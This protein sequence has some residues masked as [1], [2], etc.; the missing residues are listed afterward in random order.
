MSDRTADSAITR[1]WPAW[2]TALLLVAAALLL[3]APAF[4][5]DPAPG[6][7]PAPAA[8]GV[9]AA[10]DGGAPPEDGVPVP[11]VAAADSAA[12][13][14]RPAYPSNAQLITSKKVKLDKSDDNVVRTG[15]GERYAI[16]GLYPKG[17]VFPV[18][19]KSGDWYNVRLSESETGWIHSALCRE[20]DDLSDLEFKPN[21][22]LYTRTGS[23]MLTGYAGAYAFDRK[24]NSFVA[25]GRIGYYIFDRLQ[26]EGGLA[27]TRVRRPAEIVESLFDLSLEAEDFHMLFYHLTLT[28]ELLPG[29]QMVPYVTG[30]VGSTI[31]QGET[32]PSWN[33]GAGTMLFLS[34]KTAVRWEVRTYRFKSGSD[35]ARVTNDNVEFTMGT[36]LLF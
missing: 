35:D 7:D 18:I 1:T 3:S 27:W 29:R 14:A 31:M 33:A 21:P 16:A 28:F 25:G 30:G 9:D 26:A 8:P 15:P 34:K 22:R 20:F 6:D 11:P 13:P 17:A 24:S 2:G 32:E 23:Y 12:A 19:A 5:A 36:T 4:A 10:P